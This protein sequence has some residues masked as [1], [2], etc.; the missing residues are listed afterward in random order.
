LPEAFILLSRFLPVRFEQ[1]TTGLCHWITNG[2]DQSL[3][4]RTG[5]RRIPAIPITINEFSR[6]PELKELGVDIN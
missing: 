6:T 4:C 1:A 3:A 5:L 2:T